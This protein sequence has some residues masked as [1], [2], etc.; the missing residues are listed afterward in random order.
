MTPQD[1]GRSL[2][3]LQWR[4]ILA[5][6]DPRL[7]EAETPRWGSREFL[8]RLGLDARERREPQIRAHHVAA[9]RCAPVQTLSPVAFPDHPAM[10]APVMRDRAPWAFLRRPASVLR[11][12]AVG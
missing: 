1:L 5:T 12:G 6:M 9:A 3:R 7:H 8:P 4:G 11:A 2:Q 10:P